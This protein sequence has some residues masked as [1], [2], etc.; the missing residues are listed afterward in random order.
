MFWVA[1]SW[2][3]GVRTAWTKAS[4]ECLA[5]RTRWVILRITHSHS[6][7]SG[8]LKITVTSWWCHSLS[9]PTISVIWDFTLQTACK[10]DRSGSEPSSGLQW[11]CRFALLVFIL[12]VAGIYPEGHWVSQHD[13]GLAGMQPAW[14]GFYCTPTEQNSWY[15]WL[16]QQP[17][18]QTVQQRMDVL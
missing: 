14:F 2:R 6:S 1:L 18:K 7:C 9:Y 10:S 3:G 12:E 4:V 13:V 17:V 8:S 11:I 15:S 16:H 5:N